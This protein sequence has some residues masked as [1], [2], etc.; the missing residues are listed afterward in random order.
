MAKIIDGDN[1]IP[2]MRGMLVHYLI[3]RGIG[4]NKAREVANEVRQRL[5]KFE[6]IEKLEILDLVRDV[7]NVFGIDDRV[8]DLQFWERQ[9]TQ[10]MV[11]GDEG[12][13]PFSKGLH[14]RLV[15]RTGLAA[16]VAYSTSATLEDQ[17]L[18]SRAGSISHDELTSRTVELITSAHGKLYADRY[19]TW[20]TWLKKSRPIIILICGPSG[21][22][23]TTLAISL[24]NILEIPRV[25]ATDD[26]RQMMRLTLTSELM[27]TLHASTYNAWEYM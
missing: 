20:G 23:K 1:K 2:F 3:Q 8:G 24:A 7:I 14:A 15:E 22:G 13:V 17:L 11:E 16:D 12:K 4:H 9:I 21:A 5:I 25:V 27:P 10:I 19:H 6:D 26:I 18:E